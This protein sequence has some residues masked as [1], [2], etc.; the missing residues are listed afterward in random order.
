MATRRALAFSGSLFFV[1]VTGEVN[2]Q[3]TSAFKLSGYGEVYYSFDFARLANG[4]RP[5]FLYNHKRHQE[6]NASVRGCAGPW[7]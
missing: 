5:D 2:G 6:F 4:E 1:V 3:D 7:A